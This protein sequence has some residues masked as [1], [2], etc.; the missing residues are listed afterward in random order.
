MH[1]ERRE[2]HIWTLRGH[3]AVCFQWFYDRDQA[4]RGAGLD[5]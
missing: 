2:F 3:A 4:L 1:A 5:G